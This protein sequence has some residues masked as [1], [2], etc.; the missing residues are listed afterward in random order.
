MAMHPARQ[1]YVEEEREVSSTPLPIRAATSKSYSHA[2]PDR[3]QRTAYDSERLT[4]GA[5]YRMTA[6]STLQ[7][8]VCAASQLLRCPNTDQNAAADT[9]Y[10]IPSLA[11]GEQSQHASTVLG[12]MA[13]K[14][15]AAALAVPTDDLRVRTEL[16]AR[17]EPIT[18]FGERKEDRRDRLREL[19]LRAQEGGADED[20]SMADVGEEDEED[21]EDGEFYIQ[22]SQAL[23]AARRDIARY[24]LPRTKQRLAYQRVESKIPV[25]TH[26]K[27]RKAIKEKLSQIE[28]F[29]SQ[30]AS[31]RPVG[32]VRFAPNGELLACGDW[33]GSVKL[34]DVPNL[35]TK[36]VLRG[37]KGIVGGLTWYPGATL[38]GSNVSPGSVNLASAAQDNEIHLWSLTQD[39]PLAT[40]SGHSSRVCRTEFHPSGRYLASASYD[41]TW[42]LWDVNTTTELLLQEGHSKEAFTVSFNDDGSLVASAGLDSIGRVWDLRTGRTEMLLEG[43]TAPIYALD[44]HPDCYRVMTG[45]ADASA[46]VFDMRAVKESARLGAHTNGVSD[47]RWFRGTD[48]PLSGNQPQADTAMTNGQADHA[49]EIQP[50]KSGTFVV[51]AG[52][53]KAVNVF[54]ADDWA[55]CKSLT[56]HDSTVYAVDVTPDSKWIASCGKDRTVKL[57][58]RDDMEGIYNMS[59]AGFPTRR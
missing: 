6:A 20:E 22:G 56:G 43:H 14:R 40:L 18:L 44:W 47:V 24:S 45:S 42:R 32:I 52:F 17:G 5:H 38:P 11:A 16:R 12:E 46:R 28:L 27:H 50:K 26:V 33:G 2:T 48:G 37:H 58:A 9:N 39:T 51:T 41:T 35:E 19:M 13:R 31:E 4:D 7:I 54:S 21:G 3:L 23:L 59:P 57:W 36:T 8:Y 55:L 15:K 53:D 10:Q 49:E 29:G 30:I 1:A 34:L 25:A